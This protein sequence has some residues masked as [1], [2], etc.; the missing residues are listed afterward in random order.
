MF[1][2]KLS[3][4]V[5]FYL[6]ILK[7][8]NA[9]E[10]VTVCGA[11]CSTKCTMGSSYRW[12]GVWSNTKYSKWDYCSWPGQTTG[13]ERCVS[14]CEKKDRTPYYWCKTRDSWGYCSPSRGSGHSTNC[15]GTSGWTIFGILCGIVV[16]VVCCV[17]LIPVIKSCFK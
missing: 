11:K 15:T 8:T 2:V 10:E 4:L 7:S 5:I 3:L 16:A 14:T 12:C 17:V 13:G 9:N 1:W 6:I